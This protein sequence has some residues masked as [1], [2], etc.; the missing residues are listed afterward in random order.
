MAWAEANFILADTG[1]P[2]KLM[3]H[4]KKILRLAFTPG[5]DGRLPCETIIYSCVKKSG[6]TTIAALVTEWFAL[7]QGPYNEIYMLANDQEQAQSRAFQDVVRSIQA[8]PLLA[9]NCSITKNEIRFSTGTTITALASD[10]AGAAG[11]RHGLTCWD[12]LW[13]YTSERAYRLWDELTPIPTKLNSIRLVTTYAGFEGESILL[14]NLYKQG[15][16]GQRIDDELPIYVNGRLFVY[17]DHEPRMPWQTPEYY[18]EQRKS[19]R[20][21][22]YLRLH[23]NRWTS[24]ESNFVDIAWWDACVKPEISPLVADK[25]L[26]VWVG[27]D[28]AIK[29]DSAA[30]VATTWDYPSKKV[31][32]VYHRVFQPTP[33]Q[34]LDLEETLEATALELNERFNLKEVR[35]D[36]Y[37]F[38]RSATTLAKAGVPMVEFPQSTPNLTA[39]SQNL[40]ELIKGGNLLV[41]PDEAMR[42]SVQ[43]AVALETTRGWR[44]T[45][46]KSSHKIDVVVALAQAALGAVEGAKK[47]APVD[48]KL[49]AIL[50]GASVYE[51][52]DWSEQQTNQI[53]GG[54]PRIRLY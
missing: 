8:H 49:A 53:F 41:Y 39:A 35:Y 47:P 12:E 17:W 33:E 16:A 18:E 3:P 40:Y 42:L 6:K 31:R 45:K 44:I 7:T 27:I 20:T 22:T 28:A 32:L 19:L 2:I 34:P 46:E 50:R 25:H 36:P 51:S 26:P 11:S 48:P 52:G 43:R 24:G 9:H 38:H 4:Q 23:E 10:Y 54:R 15:L 5:P 13:A 37:Q 14:E 30:I 21:N 1:R 29:R